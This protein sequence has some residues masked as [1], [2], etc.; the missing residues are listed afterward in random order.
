[1][2]DYHM[3]IKIEN[4]R[5]PDTNISS[6]KTGDNEMFHG[7]GIGNVKNAVEIEFSMNIDYNIT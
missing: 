6:D 4:S 1:M 3:V 2:T 5:N 7:Y